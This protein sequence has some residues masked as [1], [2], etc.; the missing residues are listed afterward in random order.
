MLKKS[1]TKESTSSRR[2]ERWTEKVAEY[3][4]LAHAGKKI[5]G[6]LSRRVIRPHNKKGVPLGRIDAFADVTL[7]NPIKALVSFYLGLCVDSPYYRIAYRE[8]RGQELSSGHLVPVNMEAL[9]TNGLT[10][11]D[12]KHLSTSSFSL[13]ML[14]DKGIIVDYT[15]PWNQGYALGFVEETEG[16]GISDDAFSLYM[17]LEYGLAGFV[18]A[19]LAD[20][21]DTWNK[22]TETIPPCSRGEIL[23]HS[24]EKQMPPE[25]LPSDEMILRALQLSSMF[26]ASS[27]LFP[28]SSLRKLL[29]CHHGTCPLETYLLLVQG[30]ELN[31]Q[32]Q[33]P[34]STGGRTVTLSNFY[35]H[36]KEKQG[37]LI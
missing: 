36:L 33:T 5:P 20:A 29:E 11:Q 6:K 24:L 27:H 2:F 16:V 4:R 23:R 32:W 8:A 37:Q 19:V 13:D 34:L 30:R 9:K 12:L 15:V 7:G 3:A 22:A 25:I 31:G 10:L 14:Y 1:M 18:G 26:G 28:Q 21:Y 35:H 17:G